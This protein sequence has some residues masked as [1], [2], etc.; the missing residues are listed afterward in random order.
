[1]RPLHLLPVVALVTILAPVAIAQQA[2]CP[3]YQG[4]V[5]DGWVTDPSG[6][7]GDDVALE[8]AANRFVTTT[9]HEIAVV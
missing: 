1:M 6:I 8:E 9:G 5:C 4:V 3:P 2:T 7:L